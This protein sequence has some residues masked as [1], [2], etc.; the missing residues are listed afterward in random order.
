M[1][2]R[3]T[4]RLRKKKHT[5]PKLE[6]VA[7]TSLCSDGTIKALIPMLL[8]ALKKTSNPLASAIFARGRTI[9]SQSVLRLKQ[10]HASS[11]ST[12][13]PKLRL[14]EPSK[15]PARRIL[16]LKTPSFQ[17][18]LLI[19]SPVPTLLKHL[20]TIPLPRPL[21]NLLMR[22]MSLKNVICPKKNSVRSLPL[23]G[24]P[25]LARHHTCLTNV[26]SL[27]S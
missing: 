21:I 14:G 1:R 17:A 26:H 19:R 18:N 7:N 10:L 2:L 22:R 27:G 11:R 16:A 24:L 12:R 13:R 6:E 8:T 25:T 20:V 5:L 23:L 9:S 3:K 15:S 4:T